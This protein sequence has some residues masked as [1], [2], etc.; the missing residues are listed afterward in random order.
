MENTNLNTEG[1]KWMP[2]KDYIYKKAWTELAEEDLIA[3]MTGW[4][5]RLHERPFSDQLINE[6][7]EQIIKN[8]LKNE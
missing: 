6:K 4:M 1:S 2:Y 3:R 5:G 8:N 7:I